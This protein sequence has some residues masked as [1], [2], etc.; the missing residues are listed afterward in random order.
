MHPSPIRTG[1]YP[2]PETMARCGGPGPRY[3]SY[4]TA[5][6]F[7]EAFGADDYARALAARREGR[8]TASRPMSLYVHIPFC[9]SVCFYC[10]CH[11][12]VTRRHERADDYLRLLMLEIALHERALGLG[13]P[14][15]RIHLGGGSPTFLSDAQLAALARRLRQAFAIEP[16]A[17]WS[18][19]VDPRTADAERLERL[20]AMGFN[21]L[22]LGVQ[23]L[24]PEV[25][26]VVHREQSLES[27]ERLIARAR[28]LGLRS[29]SIDL[30]HGLPRQT[31]ER[32]A[33]TIEEVC[34]LRP[35][36]IA[37]YAYAHLPR[38][39]KPQRHID[40]ATLPSPAQRLA[41]LAN[42]SGR[43][44]AAGYEHI[45]M[46]HFAL[47]G[48]ALAVARRQGRLH[49]DFQ[50]YSDQPAADLLGLGVSAIGQV[51][52]CY[53]QNE[54]SLADWGDA[55]RQGRFPVAR[56]LACSRD[57]L[58]RR[59]IIMALMCQGRV[60]YET[61]AQSC[62]IDMEKA[63]HAELELLRPMADQG[64]VA[65]EPGAIVVTPSGWYVVR[66]IAMVFDRYLQA[67]AARAQYSRVL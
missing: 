39:F 3:T 41:M 38:R 29:T 56:G 43:L 67:D 2:G 46:D 40:A 20:A 4:P 47:P 45:G 6:R 16:D 5:D 13:A 59:H 52:G 31:P 49:R 57:D 66:S 1:P 62:L 60:E 18:I 42:A 58:T 64:L 21:R 28:E 36:R 8:G 48:D 65:L 37:L 14:V 61:I 26:R 32:F 17:Q 35:D 15:S 63:F 19:E 44:S 7:V 25:Q 50:G 33:T 9:E 51:A 10:A 30:I 12:I 27:V 24:D 34:R 23:D 22:S 11:K 54:K 55:L 53:S